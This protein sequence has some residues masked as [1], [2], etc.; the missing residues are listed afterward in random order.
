MLAL[1]AVAMAGAGSLVAQDADPAAVDD[2]GTSENLTGTLVVKAEGLES[3]EG[4]LRFVVFPSKDTFLKRPV[5]S[6]VV[7]IADQAGEWHAEDVPYGEYAVLVHHDVND[8]G[9]MERHWY[10]KPKEP[11]GASNNPKPRM[12]P[13]RWKDTV[14]VLDS[15]ELTLKIQVPYQRPDN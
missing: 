4:R 5:Q 7:E 12:G 15:P 2:G 8:N 6:G 3:N 11:G 10:G 9:K 1:V 13:P 14:F